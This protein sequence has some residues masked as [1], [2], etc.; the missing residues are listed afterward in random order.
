MLAIVLSNTFASAI[1]T[2]EWLSGTVVSGQLV[3][4]VTWM[5]ADMV[6]NGISDV[7]SK[8]NSQNKGDVITPETAGRDIWP[9]IWLELWDDSFSLELRAL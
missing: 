8:A 1:A 7:R 4:V 2:H 6:A 3:A 5:E 9:C